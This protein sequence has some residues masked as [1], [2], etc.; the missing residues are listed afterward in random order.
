MF[1]RQSNCNEAKH[2]SVFSVCVNVNAW[3]FAVEDFSVIHLDR[4]HC[5]AAVDQLSVGENTTD[6]CHWLIFHIRPL[7][8]LTTSLV[9]I[10]LLTRLN[11]FARSCFLN[12]STVQSKFKVASSRS[13]FLAIF[14]LLA[15]KNYWG[16]SPHLG[17]AMQTTFSPLSFGKSFMK[18]RSAVPENGC[19]VFLWR[20][21]KAKK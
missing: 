6:I 5:I 13:A 3:L 9:S 19:L 14:Q 10:S 20:T 16:P 11:A 4:M 21:E 18:I 8:I 17:M 7:Q 1:I 2:E 15:P 12:T